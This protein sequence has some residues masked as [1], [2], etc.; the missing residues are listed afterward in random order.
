[1]STKRVL[2][3]D[4]EAGLTRMVKVALEARGQYSVEVLNQP[5]ETTGSGIQNW[6]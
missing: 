6:K 5:R 4:D 1:M 3:V 2:M